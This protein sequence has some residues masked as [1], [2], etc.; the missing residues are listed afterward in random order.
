M[1]SRFLFLLL[2]LFLLG[3]GKFTYAADT[4]QVMVL[5]DLHYDG[6][7][8]HKIPAATPNRA[9]ERV[10]N[11][12][13]W[14]KATPEL[15][16]LAAKQMNNDIPFVIQVG[17]FVQGDCET[18]ELQEKMITDGFDKVK[19][20]FPNHKLLPVRGN[21]DIRMFKGNSGAPTVNA[22]FPRIAKE[23]GV[24]KINGTYTVRHD[25]DLYIFFDGF[26][27]KKESLKSLQKALADN[28]N[29]RYT[30]FITHL[31]VLNCSIGNPSWLVKDFKAVR[32]LLLERNAIIIAAHTHVPS[33]VQAKRDGKQ[34]T[35]VIVSSV[36]K[37][38]SPE[39]APGTA[40]N[41]FD[42]FCK[43]IGTKKLE[44]KRHKPFFDD[45]KTFE[46]P[47]FELYKNC[48]GFAKLNVADSGV[49]IE[50]YTNASGKPT[51][52]KKLR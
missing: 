25:K 52:V 6:M 40:I 17:D 3:C 47:V 5:G 7:A 50:Y 24:P 51:L 2:S 21:H 28:P 27:R 41:G 33:L 39:I 19:T 32:Q 30:F 44:N 13:M 22:F 23:L 46:I 11:C 36:G 1:K 29:V 18:V 4:Y 38:W 49:S 14:E 48:T 12:T 9:K 26:L 20:Y 34:L 45:M 15:L 42:T 16:T 31:P 37:D 8:Y 10:R 35:Q 43:R